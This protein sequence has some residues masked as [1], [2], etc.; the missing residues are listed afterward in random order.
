MLIRNIQNTN[1]KERS[2]FYCTTFHNIK[3]IFKKVEN[4]YTTLLTFYLFILIYI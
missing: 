3:S 4:V 1:K 2:K